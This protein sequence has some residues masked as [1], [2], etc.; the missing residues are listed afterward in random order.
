M[1]RYSS[2]VQSFSKPGRLEKK[3]ANTTCT[4]DQE[5]KYQYNEND[6]VNSLVHEVDFVSK[7]VFAVL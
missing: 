3:G 5:T 2:G 4:R 7:H 1:A 6:G